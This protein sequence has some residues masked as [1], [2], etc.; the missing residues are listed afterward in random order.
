MIGTSE[1]TV[2]VILHGLYMQQCIRMAVDTG[3]FELYNRTIVLALWWLV[4]DV[5]LYVVS[6]DGAEE[7]SK[8]ARSRSGNARLFIQFHTIGIF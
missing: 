2:Q 5:L 7:E 6:R 8:A 4:G 3:I 1:R